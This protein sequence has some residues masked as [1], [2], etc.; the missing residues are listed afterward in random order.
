MRKTALLL[1]PWMVLAIGLL[2][3]SSLYRNASQDAEALLRQQFDHQVREITSR[4]SQRMATYEQVLR[5]I[6]GLFSASNPVDRQAFRT[7]VQQLQLEKNYPGIQGIGF[8]LLIPSAELE[9]HLLAIRNE[10]F[11]HY[12][13]RPPG[14][15]P[16][17]TS[18][19]YLEPFNTRNQRAF[20]YDMFSEQIRH[21]AMAQA[22]DSGEPT[23]SGKVTLV[24]EDGKQVQAGFLLYV[25]IYRNNQPNNSPEERQ[26]NLLGWAY[27]PFRIN[28][29]MSGI[30]GESIQQ[31][32]LEIFDGPIANSET[33][34]F[35]EDGHLA[36]KQNSPPAL[37][38]SSQQLIIA[39]HPWTIHIRSLS[40]FA[41][42]TDSKR[43]L[44]IAQAGILASLLFA[45]LFWSLLSSRNRA[46]SL[47]ATMTDELRRSEQTIKTIIETAIN[48]II[49][50]NRDKQIVLFNRSAE[51]LFGYR[52]EELLGKNVKAIMPESYQQQH[53]Q[54][55]DNYLTTGT[56]KIIG[57]GREVVGRHKTGTTFPAELFI[58]E[59][60]DEN[61]HLFVG[62]I[63][64]ISDR[65]KAEDNLLLAR[66]VFENAGE[67]IVITD[68]NGLITDVNP[69][70]ERVTGFQRQEVLGKNPNI[71]KSG[72][73]DQSFYQEMWQTLLREDHWE[74]EVWDRRKNGEIFPKWIS[75]NAMR[76]SSGQLTNYVAIFLDISDRKDAEQRLEQLAFYDALTGLPN[77]LFFR[78]RL[79]HS[80]AL[81]HRQNNQL[82]LL[83]IDLDRFKWVN[84]TLG[85]SA[86]DDLL[87]E[88]GQ[89]LKQCVRES[90]TVARLGG[91]EFTIIL[92][93]A[94]QP[95]RTA[96]VAEKLISSVRQPF[97]LLGQEIYVGASIGI[98]TFPKD[99]PD[100]ETLIK[101]AD[102]AMYQAKEAGR[103]TY[104][105]FSVELY[106]QVTHR[107]SL[108]SQLHRALQQLELIPFYQ[109]KVDLSSRII[110][111]AEALVRWRKEDGSLVNPGL[112]IPLA[113]ETGLILPIGKHILTTACRHT[114]QWQQQHAIPFT[115]AVNLSAKEFQQPNFLNQIEEILQESELAAEQLEL[116]ITESIV[117]SN[118]EKAI[119]LMKEL[120]NKGIS[121]AMD[122]FGTGY[123]SLGYLKQFP[124]NTLKIDH[125]FVRGLPGCQ[126]DGAI[127][128]AIIYM[129]H[130]LQLKV[131]AEGVETA[132]QAE[133]LQ[134]RGCETIQGYW[135]GKPMPE[136]DFFAFRSRTAG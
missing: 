108:E 54:Y 5:G 11:A 14:E 112:F 21:T 18:I 15:R 96:L 45:A 57:I 73:H 98:A 90:D 67:A 132:E 97:I 7:Y 111:G 76:N 110:N 50:I 105:F 95:E 47:A 20:G 46:V 71:T 68:H 100:L 63:H 77:R 26:N 130:R 75:I 6:S 103:N 80:L 53:D 42:L 29:L 28:N 9:Q 127:V 99:A 91:D 25:P 44:L 86:G 94:V 59:M 83:F 27:S 23:L 134:Q 65:K 118:M 8:S 56:K 13:V 119:Q 113:E 129:A 41:E 55:V 37:F 104:R 24:Q 115:I 33:L 72:R 70:Y 74:G 79:T 92:T 49:V 126:D 125:S 69:A 88:V 82:V 89:R 36:N 32:D 133:Y 116:E 93:S 40:G 60:R 107:I 109:P 66:E 35:D 121:L 4:I 12:S 48:G 38:T 30:L 136:Q 17:Y 43:P 101:H 19:I 51:T 52:A 16:F 1:L 2:A 61:N 135:I 62:I 84:D 114:R 117:M 78:E 131:V 87:K 64:D 34:L 120:R 102:M 39:G 58:G 85:H 31:L 128:D 124:I 106:A 3:T 22:R 122:D 123:S 81:A 10:G